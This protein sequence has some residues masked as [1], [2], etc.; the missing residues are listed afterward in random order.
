[1]PAYRLNTADRAAMRKRD[2]AS[3]HKLAA[4]LHLDTADSSPASEYRSLLK[5]VGGESSAADLSA[6]GRLAVIGHLARLVRQAGGGQRSMSPRQFIELLWQQLGAAGKLD[7]PTAGGLSKFIHRMT[8]VHLASG[9]T[10]VQAGK[11][12]EALKAWKARGAAAE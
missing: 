10:A 5:Q 6:Q 4:Q 1:M 2:L 3:I 7:D 8:G 11:V 12:I 9:L